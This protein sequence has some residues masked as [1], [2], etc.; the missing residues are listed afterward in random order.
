MDSFEVLA[1]YR[2]ISSAKMLTH[3]AI[4][5]TPKNR[6][7]LNTPHKNHQLADNWFENRFGTRYRSQAVFATSSLT[8]ASFYAKYESVELHPAP[9]IVRI[10]PLGPYKYCWSPRISDLVFSLKD[11]DLGSEVG[12]ILDRAGYCEQ[13][14]RN[15]Y[16]SGHEVMIHCEEYISIPIALLKPQETEESKGALIIVDK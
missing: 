2:G 12:D 3:P 10:I 9:A 5:K 1:F 13:N 16:E 7:P 6:A 11:P 15:A 14:L 8:T 4:H